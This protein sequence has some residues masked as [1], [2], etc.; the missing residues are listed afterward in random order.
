MCRRNISRTSCQTA[1][2]LLVQFCKSV[3]SLYGKDNVTMNMHLHCHLSECIFDYGPVYSFWCFAFERFNGILG[4][5]HVNNHQIE[6]QLMRRFLESQHIQS[7]IW[8][9]EYS[10]FQK[11]LQAPRFNLK[12]SVA[13][14]RRISGPTFREAIKLMDTTGTNLRNIHFSDCTFSL[15]VGCIKA[16]YLHDEDVEDASSM[17]S[18]LYHPNDI[19]LVS[20]YY[21]EFYELLLCGELIGSVKGRNSRSSVILARWFKEGLDTSSLERRPGEL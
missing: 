15:P 16:R 10:S 2:N 12:G 4:S 9:R 1:D 8:P 7:I 20:Q 14:A 5:Y 19:V 11:I 3:E 18:S 17:Y 21:E 6:V 13:N